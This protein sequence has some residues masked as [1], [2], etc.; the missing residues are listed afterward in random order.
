MSARCA[1]SLLARCRDQQDGGVR[2][3]FMAQ[4]R[5]ARHFFD[6]GQGRR[7]SSKRAWPHC[8]CGLISRAPFNVQDV[9]Q[10][11]VFPFW[12]FLQAATH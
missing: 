9:V 8:Y 7:P 3:G 5:R 10:V 12:H 1:A 11:L 4:V 2:Y 6:L